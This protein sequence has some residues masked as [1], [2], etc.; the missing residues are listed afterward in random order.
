MVLTLGFLGI[1]KYKE[2]K[3]SM[4]SISKTDKLRYIDSL[5]SLKNRTYLNEHI[6]SWDDSEV[7]PQAIVIVDLNNIAY[8][9]DNYGHQEGDAVIKEAANKLITTQIENSEI[10]RTDGNEFLIYLVGYDEKQVVTYIRKLTKE[11]KD[12]THGY[13]AAVG[14]SM[15]QDAIKTIDDAV[16]EATLDMRSNKEE[17]NN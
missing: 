4:T 1:K 6:E 2:I 8:I 12:L 7:Y 15:I 10:I 16:N 5:T 13:G 14:Y 3:N 9:N 17:L 11:M